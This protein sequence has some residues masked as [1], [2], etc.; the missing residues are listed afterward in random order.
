[1]SY[2]S[3]VTI[4]SNTYPVGSSLYGTCSTAAGTVQKDVTLANFDTATIPTGVTIHVKFTNANSAADPKLK[5]GSTSAIAIKRYGTT[6]PSTSAATSWQAGAVVS[7]TYDGTY[8]MMNDWLN[9]N[10]NTRRAISLNGTSILSASSTTALNFIPGDHIS[11]T[12]SSGSFTFA[13]TGVVTG[14]KGASQT[15]YA[16]GQVSLSSAD[17]GAV[18]LAQGTG[19]AGKFL[20]VN[21]S[22]NVEAVAMSAWQGGEY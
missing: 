16:T 22:G 1:M 17:V 18:A 11:I 7:F 12:N 20:V 9:N 2:V 8:W 6:A 3:Q 13:A 21:S 4:G 5:V 10:D 14:V 19:N 15:D